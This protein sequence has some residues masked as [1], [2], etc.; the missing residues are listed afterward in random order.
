MIFQAL[1][2]YDDLE[3]ETLKKRVTDFNSLPDFVKTAEQ[4]SP[5]TRNQ[6]PDD[7][8]ALVMLDGGQKM[9]KYAC[10]DK[11]N[12][13]LSVIYFLENHDRLPIE[14]QKTAA[15][16]LIT[17]CGWHGLE[18]PAQLTKIALIGAAMNVVGAID[19]A[20]QGK[21]NLAK[22]KARMGK[23]PAAGME[24]MKVSELTGSDVMPYSPEPEKKKL[25][26]LHPHVDVTGMHPPQKVEHKQ[27]SQHF[28]LIKEGSPRYPIDTA[29]EVEKAA[30]Y[31]VNYGDR[32]TP[33]ERHRYCTNLTKRAE[34][35]G[36]QMPDVVRKYGSAGYDP[37]V[38]LAIAQRR[39]FFHEGTSE[40]GLVNEL[41]DKCAAIIP[42]TFVVMLEQ[43]DRRTGLADRW[44]NGVD[45]PYFSVFGFEK[46]ANWSFTYAN[47][48]VNEDQLRKLSTE[49]IRR[50]QLKRRFGC[51][52]AEEFEAD[53]IKIFDSLPL[54]HKRI[55]MHM[56]S[57]V[58]E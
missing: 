45:D 33:F 50:E 4:L 43:F 41:M 20:K 42:E 14:A 26:S 13:T 30:E 3:G 44:G 5:D 11:G 16:N 54:E 25:A 47:D 35:L 1:D 31:F 46:R 32:F 2:F 9:R 27:A 53:P 39:R 28:C 51:D 10:T 36:M 18:P 40:Y 52:M 29:T 57:G 22:M 38:K 21:E 19:A 6:L 58:E 24:P 12:T 8:Y 48:H 15:A 56:A 7:V 34:A 17:A 49:P 37:N 23:G 55:L